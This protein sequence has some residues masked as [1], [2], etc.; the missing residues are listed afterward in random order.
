MTG[1]AQNGQTD[2]TDYSD[3]MPWLRRDWSRDQQGANA[4]MTVRMNGGGGRRLV[5]ELCKAVYQGSNSGSQQEQP[6]DKIQ[7]QGNA[8]A[9]TSVHTFTLVQLLQNCKQ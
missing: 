8:S 3:K 5:L 7:R 9:H 6:S 4:V 2:L 1:S